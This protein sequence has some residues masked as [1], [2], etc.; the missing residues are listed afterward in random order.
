MIG[1]E[2]EISLK[3]IIDSIIFRLVQSLER[4]AV[5]LE[6]AAVELGRIGLV[7]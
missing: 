6:S 3:L 2:Q 1:F 7:V 5:G 4:V